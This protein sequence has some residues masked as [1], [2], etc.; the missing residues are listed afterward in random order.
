M[1]I[2]FFDLRPQKK[3]EAAFL[4][5]DFFKL[6]FRPRNFSFEKKS[7]YANLKNVN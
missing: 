3:N 1:G 5:F 2:I 7:F 4:I 6:G